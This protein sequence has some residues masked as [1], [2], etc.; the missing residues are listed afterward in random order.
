MVTLPSSSRLNETKAGLEAGHE[1]RPPRAEEK[2]VQKGAFSLFLCHDE[3]SSS[4]NRGNF[5]ALLE[6]L[7]LNNEKIGELVLDKIPKN[8]YYISQDIQKEILQVFAI[9]VKNEILKE[10]RDAKF[11]IIVDEARVESKKEQMAIVLRFV[12]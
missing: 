12:D 10:I 2:I 11:C 5:L 3:S 7:A 4:I 6:L 8:A 9:R 1:G